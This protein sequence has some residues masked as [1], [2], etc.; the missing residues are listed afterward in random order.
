MQR[1]GEPGTHRVVVVSCTGGVET[2]PGQSTVR[3]EEF[4][5]VP[6]PE[7]RDLRPWGSWAPSKAR[8]GPFLLLLFLLHLLHLLHLHVPY[9][10]RADEGASPGQ[11]E[12][13][14]HEL[15]R[16]IREARA[17]GRLEEAR[18]LL[19]QARDLDGGNVFVLGTL[20][21][22]ETELQVR[23][24]MARAREAM[25]AGEP[26]LARGI[27][28]EARRGGGDEALSAGLAAKV[29]FTLEEYGKAL[30]EVRLALAA[31]EDDPDLHYIEGV[32]LQQRR[33]PTTEDR[34]GALAAFSRAGLGYRDGLRRT[35]GVG[36]E[37]LWKEAL[38]G[39]LLLGLLLLLAVKAMLSAAE[40][41][42]SDE[43]SRIRSE[44]RRDQR[45]A[46]QL[47]RKMEG[48]EDRLRR[49]ML[50]TT[51]LML[52]VRELVSSLDVEE[53]HDRLMEILM[54]NLGARQ[55]QVMHREDT[56]DGPVLTQVASRGGPAAGGRRAQVLAADGNTVP[57]WVA[58]RGEFLYPDKIR[59]ST[60][61]AHLVRSPGPL[62]SV[63]AFPLRIDGAVRAVVNVSE[64]TREGFTEQELRVVES[65]S[66]L[67]SLALKNAEVFALSRKDKDMAEQVL[68]KYLAP[69]VIDEIMSRKGKIELAT[70]RKRVTLLFA[71][72]RGFTTLSETLTPEEVVG[73]LNEFF[74]EMT[75]II[76][77]HRGTLD[78]YMGDA[79]MAFYGAP[80]SFGDDALRAVKTA[81][82][83]VKAHEELKARWQ[84]A[85]RQ[86]FEIGVG[87]NTG[88]VVVGNVGSDVRV[89]YTAIGDGVN[90]AARL[91]GLARGGQ[92]LISESTLSE[93][94]SYVEVRELGP[95]PVKG[96]AQAVNT[97]E[98][99][100]V[101]EEGRLEVGA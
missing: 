81:L 55:V 5:P 64:A 4:R 71:D 41:R 57:G 88:E 34:L 11:R 31:G 69:Q 51:S 86:P 49:A 89:D 95:L 20:E 53:I 67:A 39:S 84:R 12:R 40:N 27:L 65:V 44:Q 80:A 94:E 92:V 101:R 50:G 54:K 90:L 66:D 25:H 13:V 32:C 35:L 14:L 18:D 62:P 37:L 16:T 7:D 8:W 3:T 52:R 93:V 98:V 47:K 26:E 97:F 33:P 74:S 79:I 87:L 17:A 29:H 70:E 21:E 76:H 96:K 82:S 91:Q 85:G 10:L 9:T 15:H 23:H 43:M 19:R 30:R 58:V 45:A 75:S 63:L 78:K 60:G 72:V 1:P 28:D 83:M 59:R 100:G 68:R 22:V 46:E 48:L 61:L 36:L 38:A 2:F 99:L 77:E 73:L 56:P 6:G 24:L 42:S